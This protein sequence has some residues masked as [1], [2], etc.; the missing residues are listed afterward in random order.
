MKAKYNHRIAWLCASMILLGTV[1]TDAELN[2]ATTDRERIIDVEK[3]TASL[4]AATSPISKRIK[5]SKLS[6]KFDRVNILLLDEEIDKELLLE[7]LDSLKEEMV[8]FTQNWSELTDPLWQGQEAIGQTI[9][10]VRGMLARSATGE[11]TEKV[12]ALLMNYDTRLANLAT[13]L[14]KEK[15]EERKG[16]LKLVFA[17]RVNVL[18]S[19]GESSAV[20]VKS[21]ETVPFRN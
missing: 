8:A 16:R 3:L 7:A 14:K 2:S 13:S 11:P 5:Q 9:D 21:N 15:N 18:E 4:N 12:K 10:K 6:K 17:N 19:P 20:V 1:G